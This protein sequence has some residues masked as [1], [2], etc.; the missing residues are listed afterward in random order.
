MT[1]RFQGVRG[2]LS[3]FQ[4]KA[5]S[6]T[7]PLG[8][9]AALSAGAGARSPSLLGGR[10]PV[11]EGA[12]LHRRRHAVAGEGVAPAD[13]AAD[14]SGVGIE[15]ELGRVEAMPVLRSPGTV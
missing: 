8:S 13:G 3:S 6:T 1:V 9:P 14:G 2:G 15:E 4:L 5:G 10:T 12:L 7:T 11:T